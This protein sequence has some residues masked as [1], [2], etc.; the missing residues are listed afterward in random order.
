[1]PVDIESGKPD[2][3]EP[4]TPCRNVKTYIA[5]GMLGSGIVELVLYTIDKSTGLLAAGVVSVAAS[6]LM[7]SRN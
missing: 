3:P 7:G 1:M 5:L 4:E 6:A 2:E